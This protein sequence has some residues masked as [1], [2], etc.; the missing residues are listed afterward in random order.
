MFAHRL[1]TRNSRQEGYFSS[2]GD[3]RT[4]DSLFWC[5]FSH[6]KRP[7]QPDLLEEQ[8]LGGRIR[9]VSSFDFGEVGELVGFGAGF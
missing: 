3:F 9:Q 4:L 5:F 1:F 6:A 2:S 8:R 7:A